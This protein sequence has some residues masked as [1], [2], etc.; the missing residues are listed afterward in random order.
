LE[1]FKSI[2]YNLWQFGKCSFWPFGTFFPF[3]YV[4]TKKNLAT[5]ME[6]LPAAQL[7]PEVPPL[8]VHS[9]AV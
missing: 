1:Y 9:E 8:L 7:P 6:V 3:W 4:Q 5:L 2:L